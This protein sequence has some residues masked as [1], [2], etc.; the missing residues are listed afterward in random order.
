MN[1]DLVLKL[2]MLWLYGLTNIREWRH[3]VWKREAGKRMC[4]DGY[5]CGCQGSDYASMWEHLWETR[6]GHLK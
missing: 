5:M 6:K 4:C 3:D 1:S 2:K